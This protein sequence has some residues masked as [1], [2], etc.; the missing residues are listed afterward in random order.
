MV[1][2]ELQEILAKEVE[3]LIANHGL[4]V[5]GRNPIDNPEIEEP[6]VKGDAIW[7]NWNVYRQEKPYKT[8][9]N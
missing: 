1:D 8:D 4:A 2:T 9:E 3:K 5:P 6:Y 7:K